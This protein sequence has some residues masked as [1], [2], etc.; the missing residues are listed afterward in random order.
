MATSSA[1]NAFD[2]SSK[3]QRYDNISV[4]VTYYTQSI[5]ELHNIYVCRAFAALQPIFLPSSLPTPPPPP[6]PVNSKRGGRDMEMF[7]SERV[8]VIVLLCTCKL[9]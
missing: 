5:I 7:L 9:Q 1:R 2:G 6:L 4:A 3:V 8:K